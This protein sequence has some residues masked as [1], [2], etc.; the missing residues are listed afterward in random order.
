[1]HPFSTN[2]S[3]S[4]AAPPAS[5]SPIP[6]PPAFDR[7]RTSTPS[8]MSPHMRN[9]PRSQTGCAHWDSSRTLPR[10]PRSAAGDMAMSSST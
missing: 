3:S 4:A 7:R 10:E 2:S 9:T 5:S 1:L 6:P 8:L